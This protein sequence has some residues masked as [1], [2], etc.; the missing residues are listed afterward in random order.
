[1]SRLDRVLEPEVM[2]TAAEALAYDRMDHTTVN[3]AFVDDLIAAA[4][5]ANDL[6][7]VLDLGTGTALIPIELCRR[8]PVAR[9]VAVDASAEMLRL[10]TVNVADAGLTDRIEL[11]LADAKQMPFA[12][13]QFSCVM[14]N[15]I[16]HHI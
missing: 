12:D 16:V 11:R 10:G 3:M 9:V 7:N 4:G 15:S 13:G 14:S 8:A 5:E 2:D 1:M 6:T